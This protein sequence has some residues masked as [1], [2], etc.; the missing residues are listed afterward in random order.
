[1]KLCRTD[2]NNNMLTDEQRDIPLS[3]CLK[4]LGRV[5]LVLFQ[6]TFVLFV[7]LSSVKN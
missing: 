7:Q 1:M 4:S 6:K 3:P 5:C 2:S